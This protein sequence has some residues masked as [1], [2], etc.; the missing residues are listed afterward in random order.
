MFAHAGR[1]ADDIGDMLQMV[2]VA[3]NGAADHRIRIIFM[4]EKRG[5]DGVARA[6]KLFG[7]RGRDVPTVFL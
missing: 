7:A 6:H 2:V 3:A 4:H 5:D 1:E